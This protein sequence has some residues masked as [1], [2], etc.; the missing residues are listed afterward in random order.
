MMIRPGVCGSVTYVIAFPFPPE[1]EY[2]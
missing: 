1:S 2:A